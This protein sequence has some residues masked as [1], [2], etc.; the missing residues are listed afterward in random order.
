MTKSGLGAV[1][2]DLSQ[3]SLEDS[4]SG[5]A[6]RPSSLQR[7]PRPIKPLKAGATQQPIILDEAGDLT[8]EIGI[9]RKRFCV[10]S[11]SLARASS[12]WREKLYGTDGPARRAASTGAADSWVIQL[13]DDD[14]TSMSVVLR[15]LHGQPVEAVNL[16]S[17]HDIFSLVESA[18][19][20]DVIHLL[21]PWTAEIAAH[22]EYDALAV[23]KQTREP[24]RELTAVDFTELQQ[25]M[26]L[27]WDLGA[28]DLFTFIASQ[29]LLEVE[30]D[31]DGALLDSK[32]DALEFDSWL[33][34]IDILGE[35]V[36]TVPGV[37]RRAC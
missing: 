34:S 9:N 30:R 25:L 6:N 20:Y 36:S 2:Q 12:A 27:A 10:D 16:S 23:V 1:P 18:T 8:L 5:T 11:H 32:G 22:L 21:R 37:S 29:L 7:S 4:P 31:G 35:F 19:R 26:K 3:L 14:T 28:S 15:L 33:K 13:P 17:Q 24:A